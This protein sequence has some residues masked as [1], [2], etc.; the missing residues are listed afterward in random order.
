[1]KTSTL[2]ESRTW[3]DP[4]MSPPRARPLGRAPRVLL[5]EDDSELRQLVLE[6]LQ[7]DGHEVVEAADGRQ[8]LI[9]ITNHY[10]LRPDPEPIDLIVSDIRMPV[11]SGLEIL[12]GLREAHWTTPIVLITAF[13]ELETR[14]RAT[15]LGAELLD[16]PFTMSALRST[17]RD[18]LR[19][20]RAP[21]VRGES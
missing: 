8:L 15:E 7:K 16:K 18:L 1:M 2:S 11:I 3:V 13:A 10:R 21:G 9:R 19:A 5:A 12:Q 14:I 6:S 4:L 17:V 20:S